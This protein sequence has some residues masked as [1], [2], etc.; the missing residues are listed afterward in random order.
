MSEALVVLGDGG[1]A[2]GEPWQM[3][4]AQ[5]SVTVLSGGGKPPFRRAS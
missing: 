3:S 2:P 1:E 5:G 4:P